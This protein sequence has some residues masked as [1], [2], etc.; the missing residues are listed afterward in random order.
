[1]QGLSGQEARQKLQQFGFNE[2]QAVRGVSFGELLVSQFRSPLVYVLLASALITLYLKD[3][4]DSLVIFIAVLATGFFGYWQESRAQKALVALRKTIVSQAKVIREGKQR[5]IPVRELVPGDVVILTIGDQVPADGVLFEST[6][7]LINEAIL[8]GES[9]PV[10][11]KT[12]ETAFMGTIIS[13]G[14][15]RMKVSITGRQTKMGRIG[16]L[17]SQIDDQKTPL[18]LQLSRLVGQIS[19][20]SLAVGGVIFVL[21]GNFPLAVA[22]VVAAIPEGLVVSLTIIL[23]LGMKRLFKRKA[24]VRRFIG[25]ETLGSISTL[26]LDKTGTLTEGKMSVVDFLTDDKELL[27]KAALWCNDMRD[28]LEIAMTEWGKKEAKSKEQMANSQR[29]D[30]IPFS[31]QAKLIATLHQGGLLLVSGAPEAILAKCSH[32]PNLDKQFEIFAQQGLRLVGFASKQVS[33]KQLAISN[34]DL[35]DLSWLGILVFEDPIREGVAQMIQQC[36]QAGLKI[37]VITGDYPETAKAIINKLKIVGDGVIT[38]E[39]LKELSFEELKEV[40]DQIVLFARTAPDQKLKIVQALKAK[41]E[42]VGMMGD[43][44]NDAPA[45]AAADVGIVMDNAV[46]VAKQTAQLVLLDSNF[47][48]ILAAI[49][50]GRSIFDNIRKTVIYL[51]SDSLIE[52]TFVVGALL[53][54]FPAPL[55]AAQIIWLNLVE[56]ILPGIALAFEQ[57]EA[58]ILLRSPRLPGTGIFT[59]RFRFFTLAIVVVT[60]L[61]LWL[62]LVFGASQ[63]FI[64]A[65]TGLHSLLAVF[66]LRS[67]HRPFWRSK[68]FANRAINLAVGMGLFL[69]VLAIYW[70]PLQFLL[71]TQP[72]TAFQWLALLVLG[73]IN[74]FSLEGVKKLA[75]LV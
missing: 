60:N 1:M 5:F 55:A 68:I 17:V 49:E 63:T 31:P 43:G 52:V 6:D 54:G 71:K 73:L 30:E 41:G 13:H 7:L 50:G 20:I 40:I 69:L 46:D 35:S 47:A 65:A 64:F 45:L 75:R 22:V 16:Q 15:A 27:V 38:G 72:L 51:L 34:S 56:D 4:T 58:G 32:P 66:V 59:S 39:E 9:L 74:L 67:F 23:A 3:W 26:C 70:P 48:T 62:V 8:T 36:Y 10:K 18:Q 21:S 44:V 37:K 57:G 12:G 11:K 14:I 42:V 25:A 2:L 53:L 24:L 33:N 29:L 28:P 61:L 19:L